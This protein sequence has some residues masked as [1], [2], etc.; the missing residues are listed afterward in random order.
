MAA[1]SQARRCC[2]CMKSGRCI[3]CQCVKNGSFCVDCWPSLSNP[4][5]CENSRQSPMIQSLRSSPPKI[6]PNCPESDLRNVKSHFTGDLNILD[7]S[8]QISPREP[9]VY[10]FTWGSL[11]RASAYHTLSTI[12][13]EIIHWKRNIFQIPSG[14]AGKAFVSEIARLFQ[15]Y[16]EE[17]SLECIAMKACIVCQVLLLQKPS[18]KS[19]TR[20]H[21]NHLQRRLQQWSNGEFQSLLEEGRCIQNRL[22]KRTYHDDPNH[23]ARIFSRLMLLGKVREANNFITRKSSSGLLKLDDLVP[24][25]SDEGKT[26]M[27]TTLQLLKEKH[28]PA[29]TPT[30]DILLSNHPESSNTAVNF[31]FESLDASSIRDSA[32]STKGSA[33]PSGLD[34]TIWKRMCTSFKSASNNLCSSL[35]G[36]G[37]RICTSVVSS[38]GISAFV[39]CRLVPLNKCPGV[40]PIGVGEVPRRIISKAILHLIADDIKDAAGPLQTCAGQEGGSEAAVHAI[41]DIFNMPEVEGVLLVD[42]SN[43]F[44]SINRQAALHNISVLCPSLSTVLNNTYQAPIRMIITGSGEISSSEGTTQGDPLGMAMYAIGILPLIQKLHEHCQ[45]TKQ[46]WFADDATAAGTCESLRQW[47][48]FLSTEGPKY[49]YYP[50]ATKTYLIIKEAYQPIAQRIFTNTNIVITCQGKRHL[51]AALGTNSFIEEYVSTKVHEWEEELLTLSRIAKSYPHEAFS[52]Y[53]HGFSSRWTYL[54]R[55]IP[56]I[57]HLFQPL[58]KII[59]NHFIPA[60]TGRPP[61]SKNERLLLSLPAR[62]GGLGITKP[63]DESS[64][65]YE[66]SKY[67]TAP[68]ADLITSQNIKAHINFSKVK[69]AKVHMRNIKA[70]RLKKISSDIQKDLDPSKLRLYELSCEKGS[71]TWITTLPIAEHG[72]DL[73]KRAFRDA[74]C[75]RYGWQ[76]DNLPSS[77]AC[78]NNFTIEHAMTCRKGGYPIIRH[79]EVRDLTANL[80]T[81]VCHN[82]AHEPNLQPI[83]H[84]VFLHQ[85]ANTDENARLDIRATGFWSRAQEAF[86]DIRIFHPSAPSNC[87][88]SIPSAYKKHENEKKRQYGQRIREVERGVF[89]PLVF[90]TSGG[91][92]R[93][94]AI[95]YKR[96]AS[97]I[98]NKSNQQYSLVMRWIRC[99]I[100]FALI[101][102]AIMSI[103]GSR[104]CSHHVRDPPASDNPGLIVLANAESRIRS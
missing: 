100:Q 1:R 61:C 20:D 58:E 64:H 39:A 96:L 28:P 46:V 87:S 24:T 33:G 34:A 21:C 56:D 42:A 73:H 15:A 104:S 68:L 72:F 89:T 102:L 53:T 94:C 17:S 97:L 7:T 45:A 85:S 75:I 22:P 25:T 40:R 59:Q 44:N 9:I 52:A 71:S 76:L 36:V 16:A 90:T 12:Y 82:V 23:V 65:L 103:R 41:R 91:M 67:I 55:T 49:G 38:E 13:E 47:W 70:D 30:E 83:T 98:A 79:N 11:D 86:F 14:N 51:G 19:K 93:E 5:R 27:V 6:T 37:K 43:A 60:L 92:A 18:K 57:A 63:D 4:S 50:N 77:C 54:S 88:L 8:I 80:L 35:A 48:D 81:E 74:L 29:K 69:E 66:A 99:S 2:P 10:S 32:L 78:G 31:I 3:R 26:S 62:L 84:E 101:R 95:F